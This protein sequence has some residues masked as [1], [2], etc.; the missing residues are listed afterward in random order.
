MPTTTAHI[1]IV[2]DAPEN[3]RVLATILAPDKYH[4]TIATCGESALAAAERHIP[5]LILLDVM[6]P[7]IDD[8]EV[9]RRLKSNPKT[10]DI[11]IVFVTAAV[12]ETEQLKR[13][14]LGAADYIYKPFSIPVIQAKVALHL[15]R[16]SHK[17]DLRLK[18]AALE[19][20]INLRDDIERI[21][22]HDLKIP[23]N[24]IL[25]YPQLM[26]M[27]DNLTEEQRE[28]LEEILKA[29]NE[30]NNRINSLLDLFKMETDSQETGIM[31]RLP[32]E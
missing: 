29:G 7:E 27:D 17:K 24:A 15:E 21:T 2:D 14:G 26:L 20:I 23:L 32:S 19:E 12:N 5:D 6:M 25:G 11:E 8:F 13:L 22:R 30:M 28:H 4:L 16:A 31:A 3:I 1:L 18:S 9:Y 10:K